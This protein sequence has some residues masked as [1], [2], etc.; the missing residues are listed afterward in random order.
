MEESARKKRED[1]QIELRKGIKPYR[2]EVKKQTQR[3]EEE[4]D[5]ERLDT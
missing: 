4:H 5:Y 2:S 3:H 1:A